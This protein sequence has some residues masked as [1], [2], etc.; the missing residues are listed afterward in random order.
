MLI[1]IAS[2]TLPFILLQSHVTSTDD[3]LLTQASSKAI[4]HDYSLLALV[5]TL[6]AIVFGGT[7]YLSFLTWLP[8]H[9][10]SHFNNLRSLD[11]V[12]NATI[13]TLAALFVPAG[14]S[15]MHFLF[16]PT[17]TASNALLTA[18]DAITEDAPFDPETAT[19]AQTIA[20]NLG[21]SKE[22]LSPKTEVLIKRTAALALGS[23][24]NTFVRVFGTVEGA[25]VSGAIGWA[26]LWA[27]AVTAVGFALHWVAE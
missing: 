5:S 14:L 22:G 3:D 7:L 4:A 1:D 23:G 2:L 26:G 21:I 20:Y 12:H 10:I 15:A 19:L 17:V 11:G 9:M 6:S 18:L 16:I 27:S 8:T 24:I 13:W 25:E